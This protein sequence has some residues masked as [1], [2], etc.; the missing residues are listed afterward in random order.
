[1]TYSQKMQRIGF[2]AIVMGLLGVMSVAGGAEHVPP[3]ADFYAWFAL[4]GALITSLGLMLFGTS[5]L[6]SNLE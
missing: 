5:L 1:M 2:V 4:F 6:N 3:D